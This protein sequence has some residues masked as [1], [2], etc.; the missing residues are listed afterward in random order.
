MNS[1]MQPLIRILLLVALGGGGY[2]AYQRYSPQ[3]QSA[4]PQASEAANQFQTKVLGITQSFG[5]D[6]KTVL[7]QANQKLVKSQP[8][9]N[10]SSQTTTQL[11]GTVSDQVRQVI[12]STT[13]QISDQIKDIPKHEAAKITRQVCDQI[14]GELEK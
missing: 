4:S 11:S 6:S 12:D 8:I 5:I 1:I 14:I 9:I 2:Y 13:R 3:L 7:N 10:D